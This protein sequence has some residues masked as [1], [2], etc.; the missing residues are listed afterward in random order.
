MSLSLSPASPPLSPLPAPIKAAVAASVCKV[1]WAG[2]ELHLLPERALWW[3]QG[4]TLFIA[5][6]HMGKA[7]SYRALG[8]P[9]PGGTTQENLDRLSALIEK[10]SP[11]QVIFLGDFLHAAAAR[12]ARQP[13]VWSLPGRPARGPVSKPRVWQ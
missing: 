9:V 8:Q 1:W 7:A 11:Q 12:T 2:V 10:H 5:D 13:P 4:Q 3:P 6:L